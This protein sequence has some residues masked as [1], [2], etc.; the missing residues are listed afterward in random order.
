M[1]SSV[2]PGEESNTDDVRT[3]YENSYKE[4]K[5]TAQRKYPNEEFCRFMGR[6]FFKTNLDDRSHIKILE[7]G[8]GSGSNLWMVAKEGFDAYGVDISSYSLNLAKMMLSNYEV[9]ASLQLGDMTTLEF[10]DNSFDAVA[11]IFSSYCLNEVEGESFIRS[12][13]RVLKPGGKFFSFFPCK[14]SDAFKNH[15]PASLIDNSTL[16]GIHRASS[17][18]YGN[19]YTFRFSS[20]EDY[21]SLLTRNGFNVTY[22]E[23]I[24]RSYNSQTENFSFISIEAAKRL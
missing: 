20:T 14:S 18:F 24:S 19:F 22:L 16:N 17:P 2:I 23:T 4:G 6:N 15:S 11:D 9:R 13:H 12:V 21:H 5:I 1:N 10:E 7:V 3:W 8:C